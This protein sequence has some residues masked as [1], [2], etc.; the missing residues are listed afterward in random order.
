MLV[1]FSFSF[2]ALLAIA[3]EERQFVIGV[4]SSCF[5]PSV[6]TFAAATSRCKEIFRV[7]QGFLAAHFSSENPLAGEGAVPPAPFFPKVQGR[8]GNSVPPFLEV[9]FRTRSTGSLKTR[10]SAKLVAIFFLRRF[11]GWPYRPPVISDRK[12]ETKN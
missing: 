1:A 2:L 3:T 6:W 11:L 10:R 5:F 7:F 8:R 12:M 4:I 9:A